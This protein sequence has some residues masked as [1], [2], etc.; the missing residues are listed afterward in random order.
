MYAYIY[1]YIYIYLSV[2]PYTGC[3]R[4]KPASFSFFHTL[5][6][7][8]LSCPTKSGVVLPPGSGYCDG[9]YKAVVQLKNM[10]QGS[11]SKKA[12]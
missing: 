8:P 11:V 10:A 3:G 5:L 2:E 1:I 12:E 9:R 7:P 6:I 4:K